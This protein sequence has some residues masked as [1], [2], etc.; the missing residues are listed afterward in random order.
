MA[1]IGGAKPL[2]LVLPRRS[3]SVVLI[4]CALTMVRI[5]CLGCCCRP[6]RFVVGLVLLVL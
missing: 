2:T 1:L 6:A 3:R 4:Y 5:S